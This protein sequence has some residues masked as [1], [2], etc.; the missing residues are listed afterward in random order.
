MPTFEARERE[1]ALDQDKPGATIPQADENGLRY[2]GDGGFFLY[3][4]DKHT[5]QDMLR[6]G[7]FDNIVKDNPRSY[8]GALILYTMAGGE[9]DPEDW[10]RGLVTIAKVKG[11]R[12]YKSDAPTLVA[13]VQRFGRA[14]LVA[15]DG[16]PA[17]DEPKT[18]KAA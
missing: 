3:R 16:G 10:Q 4:H 14:T 15:H 13:I 2:M 6:P 1:V 12:G 11:Q 9:P 8:G 5:E 7:Y 18:G 17:G